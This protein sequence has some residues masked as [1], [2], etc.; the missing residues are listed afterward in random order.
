MK[1]WDDSGCN[2]D[3]LPGGK[4]CVQHT[5][6]RLAAKPF[7]LE[8]IDLEK[9][10]SDPRELVRVIGNEMIALAHCVRRL[11]SVDD[12]TVQHMERCLLLTGIASG[13]VAKAQKEDAGPY[14]VGRGARSGK[15]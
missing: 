8:K 6:R 7:D 3:A 12:E 15:G 1:C 4:Y 11:P 2:S 13:F 9:C 14:Y 10:A 5:G